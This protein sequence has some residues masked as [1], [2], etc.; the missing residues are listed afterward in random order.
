[1]TLLQAAILGAVQGLTEFLPVSSSGHLIIGQHFLGLKGEHLVFDAAVH[2]GTLVAV[3]WVFH[4]EMGGILSVLFGR[5]RNLGYRRLLW[6][7]VVG[8]VFTGLI[9]LGFKEP[10]ERLYG[11]WQVA[12]GM[13]LVTGALLFLAEWTSRDRKGLFG[14]GWQDGAL[15]GIAQ[16]IAIIPGISRSGATIATGLFLGVERNLAAQFSFL[17]AIPAIL[18]AGLAQV[19]RLGN[20]G[21]AELAPMFLGTLVAAL[22]GYLAIKVL[23]RAVA[24]GRLSLFAYYCWAV[25]GL[26]LLLGQ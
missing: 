20:P 17:L 13:L 7:I 12:A 11:S 4:R 8:S 16:G 26:V 21:E 3:L 25:G 19:P 2:W 5:S 18:G 9:G 15:V 22:T 14:M 6:L 24:R 10:L 1:M 23:L